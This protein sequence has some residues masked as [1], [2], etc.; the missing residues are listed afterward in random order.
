MRNAL[1]AVGLIL[2]SSPALAADPVAMVICAPGYP[3]TTSEA[4]PAIDALVTAMAAAA[5]W[6]PADL[7]GAYYET[8]T[9]G[10]TR[11]SQ[12]DAAIAML[13]LALFLEQETALKLTARQAAIMKGKADPNEVW[14]LVAKKGAIPN[15]AALA[16]Y[17]IQSIVGFSP[18]FIKGPVL[19]EWGKLPDGVKFTQS[20]QMLSAMRKAAKGDKVAMVL[21]AEQAAALAT[22]PFAGDL[23][24]VYKSAPLPMGVVATIAGKIPDAK[25]KTLGEALPKLGET[26]DGAKAL[27]GVWKLRFGTLDPKAIEAARKM[28]AGAK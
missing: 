9:G 12:P 18:K 7:K 21:D 1:L 17:E 16:G 15:A 3:G 8:E 24:I 28:F 19:G 22:S 2:L 11:L 5:K 23:E 20:K 26:P 13:P 6:A 10:V 4:Q 14:S 27:E 25:W